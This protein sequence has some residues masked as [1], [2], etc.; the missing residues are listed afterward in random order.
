MAV[1]FHRSLAVA[2]T[3]GASACG[4]E[5]AGLR[6]LPVVNITVTPAALIL[7]VGGSRTLTAAVRDLEGR[8]LEGREIEWSSSAPAV[9]E[10]SATGLVTALA[11]GVASVGAYSDQS[12]GF[13][14]VVVQMDFRLPVSG[15][16]PRLRSETGTPTALCPGG[17]GGLRFDGGRECAHAGISRYSLDFMAVEQTPG[18]TAVVS[19]AD[20]V[21]SDICIQPPA[22]ATCGPNGPFVYIEHG[23]GFATFYSHLDPASVSVRR[24]TPVVQGEALGSMGTWGAESYPWMHFELRYNNQDPGINPVLDELLVDGRTLT[25]YRVSQ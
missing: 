2:L 9:V 19:G 25:E 8:P 14:R 21:V 1:S 6:T 22:E 16:G 17:E 20:G 4:S 7:P 15:D 10:V 13:A 3:L 23:F 11:P 18:A 24:K 5:P 12:V